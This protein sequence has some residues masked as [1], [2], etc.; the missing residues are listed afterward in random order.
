MVVDLTLRPA[1]WGFGVRLQK[2]AEAPQPG[3]WTKPSLL[4]LLTAVA[5]LYL[6]C[7]CAEAYEYKRDDAS[8][9]WDTHTVHTSSDYPLSPFR[10]QA[11]QYQQFDELDKHDKRMALAQIA[12][13]LIAQNLNNRLGK[14]IMALREPLGGDSK[15]F[16]CG[17]KFNFK[18][19]FLRCKLK[20]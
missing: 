10:P 4:P 8:R 16:K 7:T 5:T 9:I 12:A 14:S 6:H 1:I 2:Q 18:K 17:Q 11:P 15:N 3:R 19:Y 13:Q 20:F